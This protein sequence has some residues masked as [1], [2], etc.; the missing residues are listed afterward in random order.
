MKDKKAAKKEGE[1]SQES[2]ITEDS[3]HATMAQLPAFDYTPAKLKAAPKPR[4]S[5]SGAS[6]QGRKKAVSLYVGQPV[7]GASRHITL[8]H[9]QWDLPCRPNILPLCY[10][11]YHITM[12]VIKEHKTCTQNP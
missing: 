6:T 2:E 7:A 11:Q 4:K 1:I 10:Q 3:V 5:A 12:Q 8:H 9:C